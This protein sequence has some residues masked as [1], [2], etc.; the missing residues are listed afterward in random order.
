MGQR[1]PTKKKPPKK[2]PKK[3]KT[4]RRYKWAPIQLAREQEGLSFQDLS[5]KFGPHPDTIRERANRER[6]RNPVEV[7][8]E[9]VHAAAAENARSFVVQNSAAVLANRMAHAAVT[10]KIIEFTRQKMDT[11]F[12]DDGK[13][14]SQKLDAD[15]QALEV[16]RLALVVNTIERTDSNLAGITEESSSGGWRA[17]AG[18][19]EGTSE[20]NSD[21]VRRAMGKRREV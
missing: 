2:S 9:I 19:G 7:R 10:K 12:D 8:A 13:I 21:R 20:S 17:G 4:Q 14:V 3:G 6:W 15:N 16:R 11:F 5:K 18:A 1:K